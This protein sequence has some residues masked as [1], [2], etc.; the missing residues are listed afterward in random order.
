MTDRKLRV[1]LCH[2]SEDK[3]LVRKLYQQLLSEGWIEPWLDEAR[4]LPGQPWK[5][6]I[7]KALEA[8]D[9][10]IVCLSKVTLT[11]ESYIQREISSVVDISREKRE[12]SIFIVPIRLDECEIPRP[13]RIWQWIDFSSKELKDQT[14]NYNRLI[15]SLKI[16]YDFIQG[17]IS[18]GQSHH[19][20]YTTEAQSTDDLITST[21]GGFS[22]VK[23]PK[24]KFVMGSRVSN[25]LAWIVD[26]T[27]QKPYSFLYDYW[28]S[29]YPIT[30]EQFGE[31]AVSNKWL[32]SLSPGLKRKLDYP[33]VKVSWHDAIAYIQW[34]NKV[35]NKEISSDLMFRL[36][37]EA[38]WER[39]SRG[40]H[41][42]EW[43]WGNESLDELLE[44]Q[45]A[46]YIATAKNAEFL[47]A[48]KFSDYFA[49]ALGV[50]GSKPK[51]GFTG[52][53]VAEMKN[54]IAALRRSINLLA[55]GSFSPF[56]DS[57]FGVADMMGNIFEWT[58]SLY[59]SYPYNSQ[60]GRESLDAQGERVIRG[61]FVTREERFSVRSARRGHASPTTKER[62][63]GFRI[64]IAPPTSMNAYDIA[65]RKRRERI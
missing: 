32:R 20:I 9:V 5:I 3:P 57:Q 45:E 13:L 6:E 47:H 7:E 10:A 46:E 2:A 41:G 22:F 23:I 48:K 36:P 62:F 52:A 58:Q 11:K 63:L 27:P 51:T 4:I 30:N 40:N 25:D 16:K 56:T 24:G 43:P 42:S 12:D 50:S 53:S 33:V 49:E 18:Q 65:R 14:Y 26:E 39:A 55:V 44:K 15:K 19:Q 61:C 60:D 28:I 37:T 35:F 17:V 34:L 54:R 1:F 8:A 59:A 38:E 64:V 29:R 31:F 21:F